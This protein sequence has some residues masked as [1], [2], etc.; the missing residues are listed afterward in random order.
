M[1]GLGREL[2]GAMQKQKSEKE[3][4]G[5]NKKIEGEAGG[6][7]TKVLSVDL[8]QTPLVISIY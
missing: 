6:G 1:F 7:V 2:A 8:L 5:G 4:G 3:E